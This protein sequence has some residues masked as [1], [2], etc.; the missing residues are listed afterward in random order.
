MICLIV[1]CIPC[2]SLCHLPVAPPPLNFTSFV[3]C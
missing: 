3:D 1:V 2:P